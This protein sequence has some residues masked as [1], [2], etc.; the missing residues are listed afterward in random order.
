MTKPVPTPTSSGNAQQDR[1]ARGAHVTL[2]TRKR[3]QG[4]V[5]EA[6]EKRVSVTF[7]GSED[8][9]RQLAQVGANE[10]HLVFQIGHP[11]GPPDAV[12]VFLNTPNAT[13]DTP[14]TGGFVGSV[15][16]FEHPGHG[17]PPFRLPLTAAL[18]KA[19][20]PSGKANTVT[21]IPAAFPDR[22]ST[23]QI[24]GVAATL[25]LVLS[26]VERTQ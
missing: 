26:T 7:P 13:A 20:P 3:L 15:A 16:F 11:A 12:L 9:D 17:S 10:A 2:E 25:D 23:P 5:V 19:P 21:F 1:L 8:L 18:K 24:L 4:A 22:A 14:I 6:S